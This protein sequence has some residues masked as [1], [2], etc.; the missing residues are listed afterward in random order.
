MHDP[1]VV[2]A[3]PADDIGQ[4]WVRVDEGRFNL[5]GSFIIHP[6]PMNHMGNLE[7]GKAYLSNALYLVVE[8]IAL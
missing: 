3:C 1:I 8:I 2:A 5:K 6:V 4:S 7:A